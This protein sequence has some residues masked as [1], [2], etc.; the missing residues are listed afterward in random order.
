MPRDADAPDPKLKE[1]ADA[2]PEDAAEE[3]LGDA[4]DAEAELQGAEAGED[5]PLEGEEDDDG[6]DA[7]DEEQRAVGDELPPRR[8]SRGIDPDIAAQIAQARAD[9]AAANARADAL[10]ADRQRDRQQADDTAERA[11]LE[12]MSADERA[13]YFVEKGQ[14]QTDAKLNGVMF[15]MEDATDRVSF[16]SYCARTPA[17]AR[18]SDEVEKRLGDLRQRGQNVPRR[19]MLRQILGERAEKALESEIGRASCRERV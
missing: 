1:G 9:S 4:E 6:A 16:E 15:R 2:G 10:A 17:A 8:R 5:D 19:V 7:G 18:L 13:A 12:L 14:R 3:E 11:R